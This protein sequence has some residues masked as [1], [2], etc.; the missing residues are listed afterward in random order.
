MEQ[1]PSWEAYSHSDSQEIPPS[2]VESEGSLQCSQEPTTGSYPE[3]DIS[4]P[5]F[6]ILFL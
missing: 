5:Q 3:P 4:S 1:S 6:S 2:F